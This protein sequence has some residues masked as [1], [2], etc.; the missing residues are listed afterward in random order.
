[1]KMSEKSRN[2]LRSFL[3]ALAWIAGIVCI[4]YAVSFLVKR[5]NDIMK[6]NTEEGY[7]A[8]PSVEIDNGKMTPE[9]LLSFGRL[10]DPQLSPDGC[11]ILYS[12]S[13][14]SI[15]DNKSCANIYICNSDGSGRQQLTA[16]AESISNARWCCGGRKLIYL[17]GGQIRIADIRMKKKGWSLGND[18]QISDIPAG[19]N[20]FKLSPDETMLMY[21]ST[22]KSHVKKPSDLYANLDK[23]DAIATDDLMYRHWDHWVMDI[24]HTFIASVNLKAVKAKGIGPENSKDILESE[25][26]LYE[27][28]MEPFSG[29]EQLS[30]SPDSKTIAYSCKKLSGKKYA[31]STNSEIYLYD[32]ASGTCTQVVHGGGYDT[33]PVWSPDGSK[34]CWISMER[35]GYEADKQRLMV[36]DAGFRTAS[37]GTRLPMLGNVRDLTEKFKYNASAPV[38][39]DDS[40]KIYF[41][42]LA[43]GL[44]GIFA[45]DIAGNGTISRITGD[46]LWYDF[47]SPFGISVS[48][49]RTTLLTSYCS[50]D[51]PAELAAVDVFP[52]SVSVRQLTGE[53]TDILDR[54][55]KTTTEARQ[56]KT[57]DGKDMLT[58]VIYPPEFDENKVYPSILICLGGPQGTLSQG[59]SYR[60][61]YRLMAAQ[62]YIVVLPNRRG[63][64][65]FGQ[66]WTEQI[67][68]DYCGL[69]IQDY[70]S[71]AKALK[72]EK[73]TGKMAACGASYGGYSVYYLCG[74][75][76]DVFDAF[77]AHAGIFNEEHMYLTTE[78]MWFP[79]WD[80]GGLHTAE[81]APEVGT[82]DAPTGPAGDGETFGGIRQGGSP[83]S[84]NPAAVRHYA[85]SP[86]KFVTNW[87]TP[88]L[89]THGGMDFRVPVDEGMAAY[90]AA[91]MM[92]VP[93]RLIVF[94]DE[95]H[96]ILKPQNALFWHREYFSWLDK[97]CK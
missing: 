12:V 73:Y 20:E 82:A 76:G 4:V 89:V 57:V 3:Q 80:N 1:M 46:S 41:N 43:E 70:I 61:N 62:G 60:W 83:W 91:Q 96:W 67:S 26:E 27:L 33:C 14:T 28:P 23:A 16:S 87:H 71:A 93:S 34:L 24:P 84:T 64:T 13:Y 72:S 19:V 48:D 30:W 52:D 74:V 56:I 94:P 18:R 78:E 5:S 79:N 54:L 9:V 7:I 68:G 63:T 69:N 59:W 40:E 85:N 11:H 35:D 92:G 22:V 65:A 31:F 37:D 39:S 42:A 58:W 17:K 8:K 6:K 45:A 32:V 29:I 81:I 77:V 95:N 90:N 10:S 86:H 97:W 15:E 2:R 51:F 25:K 55:A 36:A 49:D 66:E 21:T 44:Q 47:D 53:N 38:W 88:L 50:M 75:H